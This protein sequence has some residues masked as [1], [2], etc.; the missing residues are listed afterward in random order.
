MRAATAEQFFGTNILAEL[1]FRLTVFWIS[2]WYTNSCSNVFVVS[3][4]SHADLSQTHNQKYSLYDTWNAIFI[5][6]QQ[7]SSNTYAKRHSIPITLIIAMN[8]MV[9]TTRVHTVHALF[10]LVIHHHLINVFLFISSKIR[11]V[12]RC[13]VVVLLLLRINIYRLKIVW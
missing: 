7:N 3:L 8:E 13:C 12:I 6:S 1:C 11:I 4:R 10:A 5:Y 2:F 9:I